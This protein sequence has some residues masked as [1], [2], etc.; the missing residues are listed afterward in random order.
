MVQT[1]LLRDVKNASAKQTHGQ[2]QDSGQVIVSALVFSCETSSGGQGV[3]AST[4]NGHKSSR[5]LQMRRISHRREALHPSQH[6]EPTN[7]HWA[8]VQEQAVH[9][10]RNVLGSDHRTILPEIH[11]GAPVQRKKG[12]MTGRRQIGPRKPLGLDRKQH[13]QGSHRNQIPEP[14]EMQWSNATSAM[15][16]HAVDHIQ[17][18]NTGLHQ[19]NRHNYP[20]H[21]PCSPLAE[22][23]RRAL[24]D[25][26]DISA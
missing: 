3:R 9:N 1:H 19:Q 2:P 22:M 23:P 15:N 26:S 12:Q 16:R 6:P 18:G 7:A 25:I 13:V 4:C 21:C 24:L 10:R 20:G 14:R 5:H 8:H 11:V 17:P